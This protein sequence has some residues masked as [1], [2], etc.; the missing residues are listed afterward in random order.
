MA[1][2][3]DKKFGD[4]AEQIVEML[5]PLLTERAAYIFPFHNKNTKEEGG[6]RIV[7]QDTRKDKTAVND[8]RTGGQEIKGIRSFLSRDN[9]G[10]ISCGTLPF[11][12]LNN[13]GDEQGSLYAI[14]FP[15]LWNEAQKQRG[16]D[17]RARQ[18][19]EL[20]F[21]LFSGENDKVFCVIAFEN[22]VAL[23]KKL[24]E[25]AALW[26][27]NMFDPESWNPENVLNLYADEQKKNGR[28]RNRQYIIKGKKTAYNWHV[29]LDEI[30]DL[31]TVT[32]I[33]EQPETPEGYEQARYEFLVAASKGRIISEEQLEKI[34]QDFR[35]VKK[36]ANGHNVYAFDERPFKK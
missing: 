20:F 6:D 35:A 30:I 19:V 1:W 14:L 25:L 26:G 16:S 2:D 11:E 7:I 27:W 17:R 22:V 29:P 32:G 33:G 28:E 9:D 15:D 24:G 13:A 23:F 5:R 34:R 10:K 36:K 21:V 12:L 4:K 18:P 3:E 8:I 31:A